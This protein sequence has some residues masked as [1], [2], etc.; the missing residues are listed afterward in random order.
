MC[1]WK[2]AKTAGI[3]QRNMT[4]Y[5]DSSFFV[6]LYV[7]DCYS[8]DAFRFM[9]E[10]HT[11][12][13]TPFHVA[14]WAHA[15]SQNVFRGALSSKDADR[16]H[17]TFDADRRDGIWRIADLPPAVYETCF[18][19]ARYFVPT[20]GGKTLDSLHVASALE[21]R[22]EGFRTFDQRQAGLAR[23]AGLNVL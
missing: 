15:V 3:D 11:L 14:E 22:A 6:S 19:L 9:D 7:A 16:I 20:L 12:W 23:A 8:D 2:S 4:V 18:Y 17:A 21:L 1:S 13:L 10:A 5:A